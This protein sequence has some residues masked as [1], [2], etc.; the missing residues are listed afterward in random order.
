MDEEITAKIKKKLA[1]LE[2]K[3]NSLNIQ[4]LVLGNIAD[5]LNKNTNVKLSNILQG[6]DLKEEISNISDWIEFHSKEIERC[7][8][9]LRKLEQAKEE[10][11]KDSF[12]L[13]FREAGE[14]PF[15]LM[16]KLNINKITAKFNQ[17]QLFKYA[18]PVAVLLIVAASLFLLKP[19][20][21]GFV[22]LAEE[23][24]KDNLNLKINESSSYE[25]QPKNIGNIKSIKATGSIGGNGS[26]KIYIEKDGKR[27][28]IYGNK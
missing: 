3:V 17:K 23:T 19:S 18:V 27:Y 26:V 28:L 21:T 15:A 16:E 20:L 11:I 25:W 2:A 12:K 9:K 14:K 4:K 8:A 22:T 5:E 6:V 1:E 24:Y 7:K 13:V 10:S